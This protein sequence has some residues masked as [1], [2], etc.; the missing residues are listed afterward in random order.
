MTKKILIKQTEDSWYAKGK[1]A[2]IYLGSPKLNGDVFIV[3]NNNKEHY[4][5]RHFD[6]IIEPELLE[7][8]VKRLTEL[9]NQLKV[10]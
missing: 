4:G 8:L 9:L 2:H 6:G 7:A 10:A 1:D 3:I 5:Y